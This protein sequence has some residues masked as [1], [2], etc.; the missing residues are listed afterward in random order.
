MSSGPFL[1]IPPRDRQVRE[2]IGTGIAFLLLFALHVLILR[3]ALPRS[4]TVAYAL[5]SLA[6]AGVYVATG[7]LQVTERVADSGTRALLPAFLLGNGLIL[8]IA[9]TL[10]GRTLLYFCLFALNGYSALVHYTGKRHW[11]LAF[12]AGTVALA[13]LAYAAQEGWSAAWPAL[14]GDLPWYG[15]TFALAETVTRQREHREQVEAMATDL[16]RANTLLQDYALQAEE[17]AVTRERARLAHEIHDS[18]GHTLTALDVQLELLARLPIQKTE[19]RQQVAEQA[20]ALVKK[21]LADVRRA[22]EALA[23]AALESFSLPEAIG[24][25]VTDFENT[26]AV[27]TEWSVHGEVFPLPSVLAVPLYRAAQEALTN[28]QRHAPSAERVRVDLQ[29]CPGAVTLCVVNDHADDHSAPADAEAPGGQHGL[30]GL[31]ERAE[32]LGGSFNAGLTEEHEFRLEMSLPV[33]GQ[34]PP[35]A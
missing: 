32:Q 15:L 31:R 25:L 34:Q 6:L 17:L 4:T 5:L 20:R 11:A 35:R 21:G 3:P 12:A 19:Q 24:T 9:L 13:W 8:A 28:V 14:L 10:W 30:Q 27:H 26:T 33:L 7:L 23:P 18:V 29:Y 2:G 16:V 1:P 22:V